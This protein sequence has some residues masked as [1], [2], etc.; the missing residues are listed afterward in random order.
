MGTRS[1]EVDAYIAKSRPFAQPILARLRE[2]VHKHCPDVEECLKWGHPSFEYKGM[3][4]GM[5]AFKQHATFGFWK[6]KL[7]VGDDPKADEAMGSFGC[8]RGV[9]DLPAKTKF[10]ALMK[11]AVALNDDGVKLVREKYG[12]KP[13]IEMHPELKAALAKNKSATANFKAFTPGK[14]RDY[15][16]WIAEAKQDATR[17]KRVK[18][19]VEWIAEGKHRHWK[20]EKC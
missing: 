2:D 18:Q 1:K 4:C 8:L 6:H 3:L 5:A 15:L 7:V 11:K 17:T 10:A 12:P 16:E 13:K 20:Y 19:A 9:G 14:Q